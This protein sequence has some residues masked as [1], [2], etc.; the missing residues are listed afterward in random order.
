MTSSDRAARRDRVHRCPNCGSANVSTF[1]EIRN[2][3]VHSVTL[4]TSRESARNY[5]TGDI[6]LGFCEQCSFVANL[7]F[8]PTLQDYR[9]C[10]ESTQSYSQVFNAFHEQL[11]KALVERYRLYGKTVIEIGCGQGEFLSL[12]CR[13][14]AARGIGFDPAY[15]ASRTGAAS[16]LNLTIIKDYYSEKYVDCGADFICCKMTLEHIQNT[17]DFIDT[18]R[19]AV[20]NR[21]NTTVFF[22][23]PDINR[24]L[25]EFAFW[26][27]YY[28][29][30]SYFGA[31]SLATVF[32]RHGFLI[33]DLRT[34]Y[35][36]QYLMIETRPA[37]SGLEP[38]N[39]ER[40]RSIRQDVTLFATHCQ[41]RIEAW[42]NALQSARR[43]HRRVAIWGGGS[44]AVAFLTTLGIRDELG[45]VVDINPN[46][47]GT[48]LAGTGHEIISPSR[49]CDFDPDVVVMM[50]PIYE[51]EIRKYFLS[52]G[53]SPRLVPVTAVPN[54]GILD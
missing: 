36:D 49:L 28:E 14:G 20:G 52:A 2:I 53:I 11:A 15:D 7:A 54:V 30:C 21:P 1:Y 48:F 25:K 13:V 39:P 31:N 46:K 38:G 35:D 40:A 47:H 12:L 9:S 29:H 51:Q 33:T 45:C 37:S 18:V 27:I 42:R 16:G 32:S 44:K 26:D 22:Q 4:L 24:I 17:G 10:Y 6:V 23:V 41:S 19:R 34:E 5:P 50:N 43:D 8:D 3:P